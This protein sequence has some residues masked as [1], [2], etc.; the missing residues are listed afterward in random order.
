MHL[1]RSLATSM[2]AVLALTT[3]TATPTPR[4]RTLTTHS[5][6]PLSS[7][8]SNDD[9]PNV[10]AGGNVPHY[11][12]AIDYNDA[13]AVQGRVKWLWSQVEKSKPVSYASVQQVVRD[14]DQ[15]EYSMPSQQYSFDDQV[16]GKLP[17]GFEWGYASASAQ[18]TLILFCQRAR[19]CGSD[20]WDN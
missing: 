8:A 16:D 20:T 11:G 9:N 4:R 7:R 6:V 19:C 17:S 2:M 1:P 3:T 12:G 15:D 13:Q 10:Q 18:G 14:F 5:N